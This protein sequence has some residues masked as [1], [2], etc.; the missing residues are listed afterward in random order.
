MGGGESLPY[1]YVIVATG[2]QTSYFGHPEWQENA[3][4]LKSIADALT[5]RDR[6]LVACE[7]A[8]QEQIPNFSAPR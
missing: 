6:V 2:V 3:P 4:G 7:R 8:E 5:V 1:D